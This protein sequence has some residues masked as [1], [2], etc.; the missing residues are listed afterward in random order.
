MPAHK[1]YATKGEQRL[2]TN[3][4]V[5]KQRL[6][7]RKMNPPQPRGR[8]W[9]YTT[10]EEAKAAKAER[11]RERR[12][13]QKEFEQSLQDNGQDILAI[14]RQHSSIQSGVAQAETSEPP[15][16]KQKRSGPGRPR[17]YASQ[18]EYNAVKVAEDRQRRAVFRDAQLAAKPPP[19]PVVR[20]PA[21]RPRKYK[22]VEEYKTANREL[23]R[24][25]RERQKRELQSA[26]EAPSAA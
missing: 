23:Q 4:R 5:R 21:G 24:L 13:K 3:E 6:E 1:K 17:K 26:A 2:A 11:Q 16:L 20:K 25:W 12:Q 9:M 7:K 10:V 18:E 14:L 8:P 22:D 15:A 19:V